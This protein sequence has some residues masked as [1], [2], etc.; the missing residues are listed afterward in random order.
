[1]ERGWAVVI[2]TDMGCAGILVVGDYDPTEAMFA[3]GMMCLSSDL[4]FDELLHQG[5][6]YDIV[7]HS[8]M[9][10]AA[11]RNFEDWNHGWVP[12]SRNTST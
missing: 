12:M 9:L 5:R 7:D 6:R 11:N 4:D 2:G 10:R 1:M 3:Y 8:Y